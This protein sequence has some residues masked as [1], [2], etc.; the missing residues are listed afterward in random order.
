MNELIS[1]ID[2]CEKCTVKDGRI[3]WKS[4][5]WKFPDFEPRFNIVNYD[6]TLIVQGSPRVVILDDFALVDKQGNLL[7]EKDGFFYWYELPGLKDAIEEAMDQ[8]ERLINNRWSC[9]E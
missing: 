2:E 6:G 5:F 1:M 4:R 7:T 8:A 3:F 9:L